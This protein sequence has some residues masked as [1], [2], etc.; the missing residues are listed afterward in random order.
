MC[1][2]KYTHLTPEPPSYAKRGTCACQ[3]YACYS[4]FVSRTAV[5]LC[6]SRG[7]GNETLLGGAVREGGDAEVVLF[8]FRTEP[9]YLRHK[10]AQFTSDFYPLRNIMATTGCHFPDRRHWKQRRCPSRQTSTTFL[11][12]S[13]PNAICFYNPVLILSSDCIMSAFSKCLPSVNL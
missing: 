4:R 10:V 9:R 12:V 2:L 7:S 8:F 6:R 13:F 3:G 1:M 5:K 11:F